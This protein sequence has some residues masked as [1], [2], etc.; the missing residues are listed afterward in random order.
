MSH[1]LPLAQLEQY[2]SEVSHQGK[3]IKV[4]DTVVVH[5]AGQRQP[6]TVSGILL[7]SN[8]YWIGYHNNQFFCPWPLVNLK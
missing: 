8:H 4:G 2:F 7:K 3:T 6:V 5:H 1:P